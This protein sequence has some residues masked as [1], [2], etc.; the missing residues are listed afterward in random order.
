MKIYVVVGLYEGCLEDSTV[1]LDEKKA[2]EFL[3]K[4]Y[5]EYGS[6]AENRVR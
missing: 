1:F 4:I 6:K 2:K 5:K 3:S